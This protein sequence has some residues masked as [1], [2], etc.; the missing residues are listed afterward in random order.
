[1]I[2]IYKCYTCSWYTPAYYKELMIF[3]SDE[4]DSDDE[5]DDWDDDEDE[6]WSD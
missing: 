6:D 5:D 2:L 3:S 4:D 1:M